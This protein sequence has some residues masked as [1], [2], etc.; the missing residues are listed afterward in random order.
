VNSGRT[1]SSTKVQLN[2]GQNTLVSNET[3]IFLLLKIQYWGISFIL[4]DPT[5]ID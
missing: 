3:C 1:S 2:D 4:D 5:I